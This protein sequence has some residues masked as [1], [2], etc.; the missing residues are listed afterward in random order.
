MTETIFFAG[1]DTDVGKTYVAAL[2]AKTL[3]YSGV[4]VG[5]YKPVAS[6]C[7]SIGEKLVAADADQLW[8][9]AGQPM[10]LDTVCPQKFSAALAPNVAAQAEGKTV[11][12]AL[13]RNGA[14]VWQ[15]ACDTLIVEGA[16]GL[17]SP[18]ADGLLNVDLFKQFQPASLVIVAA[19]RLGVIHQTLATC[20]AASCRGIVPTGII[21]C[22]VQADDDESV[23]NNATEIARYT[24]VPVLGQVGFGASELP[25]EM[26]RLF[27][28][29]A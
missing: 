27:P 2:V 8:Q 21:L 23:S 26:S 4:N 3:H 5:V 11:D 7:R 24:D 28:P 20:A 16:G 29:P 9:A 25:F 18:L 22:S 12:A 6:G 14:T 15:D 17:F 13:L 19:N 1:T 10:D